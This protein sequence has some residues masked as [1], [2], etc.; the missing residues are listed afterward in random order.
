MNKLLEFFRLRYVD[1]R[2]MYLYL[3]RL[4]YMNKIKK[5]IDKD[6]TI[7]SSNCFAGRVMQDMNMEYNSPTLGLWMMP[8]DF[9]VFGSNLHYY[10]NADIQIVTHSKNDL[11][12]YKMTHAKHSYPVGL[13]D[14]KLEIHFLHYH[15]SEE[16]INKWKRRAQRINQKKILMIASEQNGCTEDDVRAF[17]A[18]PHKAKLFFCSKPYPYE[19][20]VYIPEFQNLG[21]VGDPYKQGYIFYKYF[22]K[23]LKQNM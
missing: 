3:R 22:A 15:T 5:Y 16:A 21:Y 23:W 19:C 14:G 6:V 10:T 13:L 20:V 7:I 1:C 2:N 8:D 12:N 11:G 18:I 9:P 4:P 17:N